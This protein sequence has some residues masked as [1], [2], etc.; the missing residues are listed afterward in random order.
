[1]RFRIAENKK[2]GRVELRKH[3]M[4]AVPDLEQKKLV[5]P[6]SRK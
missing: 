5:V 3:K 1:M 6:D 2:L 4:V